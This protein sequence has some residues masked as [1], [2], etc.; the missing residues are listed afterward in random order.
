MDRTCFIL[1]IAVLLLP[2]AAPARDLGL[3]EAE[4]LLT[5]R[6]R[7]VLAAR[8][9]VEIAAAQ[10]IAAAARPNATLSINTASIGNPPGL[11]PGALWDKRID[12]TL[13]IDQPFERGGKRELRMDAAES[14]E[15]AAQGDSADVLRLQLA[16]VRAAYFELKQAEER[17]RILGETEALFAG[18]LA[19]AQARLRAGDLAAA[20]VSRVQIDHERSGNELRGARAEFARAQFALAYMV[21]EESGATE[22]RAADDWPAR[23]RA[24]AD[25]AEQAIAARIEARPDVAAARDRLAA[26]EHLRWLARSQRTRDV[27]VGAQLERY[28]GTVPSNSIGFGVAVPLFTGND[29]SGEILRAEV[30][31]HA[32][33]DQLARVRALASNEMRRT[34][35]DLEAAADRLERFDGTLTAAAERS[36]AAAEFA[37]RR[38]ASSVLEVLDARRQLRAVRLEALAARTEHARALA[39]W[40]ASQ[41]VLPTRGEK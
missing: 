15:R 14:L 27:T 1:A 35:A 32:A 26:A 28:P 18:T 34:A 3:E 36:A 7:E 40:R 21:G 10:R 25:A 30:E 41:P 20:D 4:R 5:A 33:M 31:R 19:A 17:I 12:T 6:S 8:R 22:M 9:L 23:V 24:G 37:F 16:Q 13:R 38:G 29:Y 11:G 39:A 2:R